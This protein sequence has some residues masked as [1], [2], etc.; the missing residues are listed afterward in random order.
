[1]KYNCPVCGGEL[2]EQVGNA[3]HPGDPKFGILLDCPH[4]NCPA[5]EIM[6]HGDNV[7]GA[8]EIVM[9]RISHRAMSK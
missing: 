4:L 8:Y 2:R 6:G 5:Q 1:M 9:A 3:M 7:K